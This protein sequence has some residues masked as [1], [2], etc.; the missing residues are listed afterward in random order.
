MSKSN[1][2]ESYYEYACGGFALREAMDANQGHYESHRDVLQE[3]Y[4]FVSNALFEGNQKPT[5]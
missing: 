3:E 4:A 1:P 2:C 5:P